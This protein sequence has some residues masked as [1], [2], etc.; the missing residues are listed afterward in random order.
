MSPTCFDVSIDNN[1]AHIRMN[2]PEKRNSMN[3]EFWDELPE[4]VNDID[5]NR[6]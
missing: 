6:G 3:A 1:I 4:I 2:R 5:D